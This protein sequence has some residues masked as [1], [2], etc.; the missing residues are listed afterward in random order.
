M[1]PVT[2]NKIKQA[3]ILSSRLMVKLISIHFIASAMLGL[4]LPLL[5]SVAAEMTMKI[6]IDFI[7]ML[8]VI[9]MVSAAY[10]VGWHATNKIAEK[11]K[12]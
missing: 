2:S 4:Q 1:F 8:P 10:F 12:W 9:V 5:R 6:Y 7:D 3:A 11:I